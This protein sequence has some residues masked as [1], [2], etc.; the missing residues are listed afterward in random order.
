MKEP[1]MLVANKIYLLEMCTKSAYKTWMQM[2]LECKI[3]T[4]A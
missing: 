4:L 3:E 1:G 2:K